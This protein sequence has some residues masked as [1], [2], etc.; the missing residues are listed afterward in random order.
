M[1]LNVETDDS[2]QKRDLPVT[3]LVLLLQYVIVYNILDGVVC[4]CEWRFYRGN[5]PKNFKPN[6]I[7]SNRTF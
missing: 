6:R 1:V 5:K 4:T 7:V 2:H 3:S